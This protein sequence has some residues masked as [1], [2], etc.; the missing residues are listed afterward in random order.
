MSITGASG[1]S[2]LFPSIDE[3][4]RS[5]GSDLTDPATR[6]AAAA[7]GGCGVGSAIGDGGRWWCWY[8]KLLEIRDD[9]PPSLQSSGR[10]S[11]TLP[12]Y[13]TFTNT[14]PF[15]YHRPPSPPQEYDDDNDNDD[16]ILLTPIIAY[17]QYVNCST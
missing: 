8:W 11:A 6:A 4:V 13:Q 3:S 1:F 2:E 10:D 9:H 7:G 5:L 15:P 17:R 16:E 12:S 14:A